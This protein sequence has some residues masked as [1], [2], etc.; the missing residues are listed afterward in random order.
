MG[1]GGLPYG[2][3]GTAAP[4]LPLC[5]P[6]AHL[7]PPSPGSY[8]LCQICAYSEDSWRYSISSARV[9][10]SGCVWGLSESIAVRDGGL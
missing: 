10:C 7:E 1:P 9:G 4:T 5:G 8:S 3:P 2:H 6:G